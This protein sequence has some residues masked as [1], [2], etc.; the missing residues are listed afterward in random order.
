M[1]YI[2]NGESGWDFDPYWRYLESVRG[3][4]PPN[5]FRFASTLDNYNSSADSLHDSWIEFWKISEVVIG[6]KRRFRRVNIAACLLGPMHD[7]L[8]HLH[9]TNVERHTIAASDGQRN[10]AGYGDLLFH[11]MTIEANGLFSHEL[12]FA[13]GAVFTVHFREFE[14][15]IEP[16]GTPNS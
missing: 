1:K 14:H 12:L 7:R 4:M 2:H 11:E 15:R 6:E 8:I 9:Y 3:T 5:I 10:A 13:S 16:I